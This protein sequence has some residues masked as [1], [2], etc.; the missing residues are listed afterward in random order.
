MATRVQMVI[1][2]ADPAKLA[3][4][5]ALALGYEMQEP[6]PGY[7]TWEDFLRARG[8]P[9]SEWN[10]VSAIV[11]PYG[12]GPRIHLQRVS[13]PKAGK[14]RLHLDLSVGGDADV[15][16]EARRER[17]F[18]E[19]ARLETFGAT[20]QRAVEDWSGFWMI[21]QDPEGNEFCLY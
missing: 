11:D 8:I 21:M 5:W 3:E 13:E 1:D 16:A 6:P 7:A 15:P 14:N 2:C 17:I 9:K 19:A 18:E 12:V 4:F 20:R 10:A